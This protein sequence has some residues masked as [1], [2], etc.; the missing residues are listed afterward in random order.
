[1]GKG[2]DDDFDA[3]IAGEAELRLP[4]ASS[5]SAIP[6]KSMFSRFLSRGVSHVAV[7][8]LASLPSGTPIL[9]IFSP[10]HSHSG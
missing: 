9:Y 5:E 1:M 6:G 4:N 8:E 7:E 10:T 2:N 3:T